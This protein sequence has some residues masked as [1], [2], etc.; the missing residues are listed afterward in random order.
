MPKRK[1]KK[2]STLPEAEQQKKWRFRLAL[3]DEDDHKKMQSYPMLTYYCSGKEITPTTGKV[4]WQ[5]YIETKMT[6]LKTLF[7]A[8]PKTSFR[9]T[10]GTLLTCRFSPEDNKA[11]C[12]KDKTDLLEWGTPLPFEEH[13]KKPCLETFTPDIE[14]RKWQ[15]HCLDVVKSKPDR[16]IYWIWSK[17]GKTGKTT[18]AKWLYAT[19]EDVCVLNGKSA[20]QRNGVATFCTENLR[21]PKTV[22]VNVPRC[23]TAEF[24]SYEALEN[25][26]DMFFYSGKYEGKMICGPSPHLIV[27]ANFE[28]KFQKMSMDRWCLYEIPSSQN[29]QTKQEITILQWGDVIAP[30][31]PKSQEDEEI[32]E[33][34]SAPKVSRQNLED[35]L[36]GIF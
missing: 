8:F 1:A 26:K 5:T 35:G 24:I 31:D 9:G 29:A 18:F 16:K 34:I 23:T 25:I 21:Y 19:Q 36:F 15:N 17:G 27:F 11:Y 7:K 12:H 10:D 6:R 14:L 28:P 22:V 2:I 3:Y 13:R 32:S 4:H 30:L 20:D 33:E